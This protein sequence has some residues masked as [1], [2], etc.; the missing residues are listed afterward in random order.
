MPMPD[1]SQLLPPK[2]VAVI[3]ALYV[4]CGFSTYR[5]AADVGID[6]QRVGRLLR[7]AGVALPPRGQG[8]R[9]P[10][11]AAQATTDEML[12]TL[13]VDLRMPSTEIGAALGISD[14][15]IRSR[16][17]RAGISLRSR[18][19]WD[20]RDR[21]DAKEGDVSRLY[22]DQELAAEVVGDK[23]GVSRRIV[24]RSAH[25]YG[26]PV[27][28]GGM[29]R[30]AAEFDIRLIEALYEDQDVALVLSG[31]AI[32]VVREPGPIWER[33][34]V[35][36]PLTDDLLAALYVGC[37]LACFHIEL[38]TGQP[39]HTVLQRLEKAA[40]VRR[41]RGGRSPF[42][43]RWLS[44]SRASDASATDDLDVVDGDEDVA[45]KVR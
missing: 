18:G 28:A 25:T 19:K 26:L 15:L 32:P 5:I 41:S 33:F 3:V 6:R 42:M 17:R 16:L 39:A 4:D 20:R 45:E 44:G 12:R 43:R 37:G 2:T 10:L 38:L 24:L 1:V 40:I 23:L 30:P 21:T 7:N 22:V 29:S 27:R 34:P 31:H 11:R 14:R 35:P 36:V 9:R 8:R 13:Y